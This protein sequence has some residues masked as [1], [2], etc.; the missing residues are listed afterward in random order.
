MDDGRLLVVRRGH[1]PEAGR[2]TIPGGRVEPGESLEDAVAREVR[3]ET[4]VVVRAIRQAGRA[5]L[6]SP[7]EGD[8]YAVTDFV[9]VVEGAASAPMAGDDAADVRWVDPDEYAALELTTGLAETLAR[10]RVWPPGA[11]A[12]S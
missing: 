11:P 10:W 5:M 9:A 8:R 4:G 2:W 12:Q 6:P 7:R 3:E 1:S